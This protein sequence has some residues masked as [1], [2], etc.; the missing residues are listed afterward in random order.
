MIFLI[1]WYR[2]VWT[3]A[4]NIHFFLFDQNVVI[5]LFWM[6][7][8]MKEK[9][10]NLLNGGFFYHLELFEFFMSFIMYASS[11]YFVQIFQLT[12]FQVTLN[13]CH[14]L[15]H[16]ISKFLFSWLHVYAT[17]LDILN[18]KLRP[19]L[20]PISMM[21]KW[22]VLLCARIHHWFWGEGGV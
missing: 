18:E 11:A 2:Q 12:G 17:I 9:N 15:R 4:Y 22:R 21:E 14:L 16:G 8:I 20:P 1:H 6:V 7:L 13:K 5:S 3:A 19:P 10:S